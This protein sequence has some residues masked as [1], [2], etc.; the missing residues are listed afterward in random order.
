MLLLS[1]TINLKRGES[2]MQN[3]M[4]IPLHY[5]MVCSALFFVPLERW[6]WKMTDKN[7]KYS[8]MTVFDKVLA[9]CLL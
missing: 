7:E 1:L 2:I 4:W 6:D 3:V 9:K 8:R 5:I